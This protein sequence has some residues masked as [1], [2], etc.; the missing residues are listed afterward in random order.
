MAQ[1]TPCQANENLQ[2]QKAAKVYSQLRLIRPATKQHLQ[3]YIKV[4]LGLIV[5][6]KKICPEHSAPLDYLWHSFNSDFKSPTSA[7]VDSIVWAN[8][9]DGKTRLII[10]PKCPRLIEAL[11]CYHYPDNVSG[12][13]DELPLK[14]GVYDHPIDALRY[15][16]V[17]FTRPSK[18]TSRPY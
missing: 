12:P 1:Q 17:N 8:R 13:S 11:Q 16:F 3:N 4:F 18:T 10:S 2:I 14:D 15:F 5:P 9:G 7:N 6:D